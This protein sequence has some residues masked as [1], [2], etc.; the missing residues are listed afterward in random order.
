MN[1]VIVI[2]GPTASGKTYFAHQLAQK[3]NGEI[4]CADS[5]QLYKQIPIVT[6]SPADSLKR[7]LPYLLYNFLDITENNYSTVRYAKIAA[8]VIKEVRLREKL[9]IVVG[10]SGLYINTLLSGYSAIPEISDVI[11]SE[12]RALQA[13]I[14]QK[15][16][17]AYLKALDPLAANKLHCLDA[18]RTIRAYEV[19]KQTGQSIIT[20]Q[21]NK[22][23]TP[24]NNVI[25]SIVL[26]N[27]ER[28]FLYFNCN[29]RLQRMFETGAIEEVAAIM[30]LIINKVINEKN[31][32]IH[33]IAIQEI[34]K[35]LNNQLTLSEAL[36]LAQ[37][38]TRRYA[39]RQVTWFKHQIK[40]KIT[41]EYSNDRE[42]E[43]L[44]SKNEV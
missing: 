43:I 40:N 31:S 37:N 42:L 3:Y 13:H 20:F 28:N 27:P 12:A 10:G 34:I 14:G 24:L 23:I 39:K 17:F 5:L 25:V 33:A 7:E 19:F 22:V 2:C 6:A 35:Y 44:V 1:R 21:H 29:T 16:F 41:L 32:K 8:Q 30:P 38:R 36:S 15:Q 11:K 9:P 4:I 18:Q 26:L